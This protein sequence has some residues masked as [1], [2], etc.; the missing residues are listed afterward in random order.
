MLT[1]DIFTITVTHPGKVCWRREKQIQLLKENLTIAVLNF[2]FC[3][4]APFLAQS[5][6]SRAYFKAMKSRSC[7]A[8]AYMHMHRFLEYSYSVLEVFAKASVQ[9]FVFLWHFVW[10]F[11]VRKGSILNLMVYGIYINTNKSFSKPI[12]QMCNTAWQTHSL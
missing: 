12:S 4:L 5:N 11:L 9:V 7:P 2:Q 3:F 1:P 6:W 8:H 10:L